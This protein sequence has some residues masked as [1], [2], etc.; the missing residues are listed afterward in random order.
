MTAVKNKRKKEKGKK[1]KIEN[2]LYLPTNRWMHLRIN[3]NLR[4][5]FD[6]C[7]KIIS[8]NVDI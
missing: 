7:K 1:L 3:D 5:E 4:Y 6:C 2:G 8:Q